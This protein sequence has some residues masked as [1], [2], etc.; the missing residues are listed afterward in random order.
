[1]RAPAGT[2]DYPPVF[3]QDS[4][5]GRPLPVRGAADG[6]VYCGGLG[7]SFYALVVNLPSLS[8]SEIAGRYGPRAP[9]KTV[10]VLLFL[11]AFGFAA[12][13]LGE[14]VPALVSGHAPKSVQDAGL[15][16]SPVHVLD[17]SLLL[18]A[19]VITAVM[20]LRRKPA[21]GL[22]LVCDALVARPS[23]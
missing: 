15:F 2:A 21:A 18:P 9:V 8:P 6:F 17:L 1:M 10:A 5:L 14:I 20:L 19:F 13:W 3:R 23:G 11:I 12:L 4:P 16:T 22:A 7:F